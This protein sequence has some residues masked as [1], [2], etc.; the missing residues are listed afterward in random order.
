MYNLIYMKGSVGGKADSYIAIFTGGS[1]TIYS[2]NHAG[3]WYLVDCMNHI[4]AW[5]STWFDHLLAV[6]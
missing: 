3:M 2:D 6:M 1:K 5:G 4:V